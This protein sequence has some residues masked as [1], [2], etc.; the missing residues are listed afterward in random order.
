MEKSKILTKDVNATLRQQQI[1]RRSIK[2]KWQDAEELMVGRAVYGPIEEMIEA[3]TGVPKAVSYIENIRSE[4]IKK[5]KT[6][7]HEKDEKTAGTYR[8]FFPSM[9]WSAIKKNRA[10]L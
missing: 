8:L 7:F 1:M 4:I 5:W 2:K 3:Y 6:L 10:L 9:S